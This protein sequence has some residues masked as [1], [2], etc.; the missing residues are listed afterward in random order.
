MAGI[1]HSTPDLSSERSGEEKIDRSIGRLWGEL[2]NHSR[3]WHWLAL[4]LAFVLGPPLWLDAGSAAAAEQRLDGL[5]VIAAPG[6]PFGSATAKASLANAKR[7]GAHAIAV[8]PFFWQSTPTS[9]S[10]LRGD[11]MTDAELG[12]AIRDAHALGLAVLVKPHVWVPESWAG[13]ITMNSEQAWQEWFEHYRRELDRIARIAEEEKAEALAIGTELSATTQRREW[14]E[15][16]AVARAAY[17]GRLLYVAHNVDEAEVVPFWDQ[18]DAIGVTLY[19]PLGADDD[20]DGRRGAMRAIA[21]RLDALAAQT[22]KAIV[23]GEVGLRSAEGAAAK[24]W[25]SAEERTGAPDPALQAAVIADWLSALNRPAIGGILIWRWFTDPD[26]GG[27]TDTDF[28]VQGKPAEQVIMCAWTQECKE[29]HAG[30][31]SP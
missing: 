9:P 13:A 25:E 1:A 11:D 30:A 3:P 5:N 14:N 27:S 29:D 24:P 12:A 19:P 7:L 15:L 10:L 2:A 8:V 6:H 26:A 21:E 22:G 31:Q 17:S 20:R 4:A 28:T 23:V 16:I 18:V